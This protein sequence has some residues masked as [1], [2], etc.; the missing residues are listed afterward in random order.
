MA[1]E[2]S[3]AILATF[4]DFSD[5]TVPSKT[6]GASA[7]TSAIP[8]PLLRSPGRAARS[9]CYSDLRLARLYYKKDFLQPLIYMRSFRIFLVAAGGFQTV[10][11]VIGKSSGGGK[12]GNC[13]ATK[14]FAPGAGMDAGPHRRRLKYANE[15]RILV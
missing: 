1:V 6:K 4:E 9:H 2:L 10:G 12:C 14:F 3:A 11:H 5:L 13:I 15:K 7:L 8:S